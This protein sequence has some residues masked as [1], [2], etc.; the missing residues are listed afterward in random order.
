M[1]TK[2]LPILFSAI[3]ISFF[4]YTISDY[5][6]DG[7]SPT[8]CQVIGWSVKYNK[9]S[10]KWDGYALLD[11]CI[12]DKTPNEICYNMDWYT[13]IVDNKQNT[14]YVKL[15]NDWP[16]ENVYRCWYSDINPQKIIVKDINWSFV[17]NGCLWLL[18][19]IIS[20]KIFY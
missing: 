14:L 10:N 5:G 11:W 17:A 19:S 3:G 2:L 1:I 7:Y 13:G 9:T 12:K 4:V 6:I 15:S 8:Y 20:M 18:F 16:W